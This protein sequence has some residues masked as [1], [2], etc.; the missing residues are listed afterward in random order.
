M[1]GF[2]KIVSLLLLLRRPGMAVGPLFFS[3]FVIIYAIMVN[4]RFFCG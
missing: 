4:F 3:N 2:A 1:K